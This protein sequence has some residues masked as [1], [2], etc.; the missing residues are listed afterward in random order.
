MHATLLGLRPDDFDA[1]DPRRA[2]SN[3]YSRP[4]LE[5]KQ[6]ALVWARRVAV[7]LHDIGIHVDVYASEEHP[8]VRNGYRVDC[9]WV[10]LTRTA[11]EREP[12][13]ALLDQRRGIA[14]V[15]DQS[16]SH[17]HAFLALR[18]DFDGV[19]VAVQVHPGA[20]IDF[21]TLQT[22]L[23]E[24]VR[25]DEL[26]RALVAL[27]EQ[28]AF[29]IRGQAQSP[30]SEATRD[31]LLAML[32]E[33]E[34]SAAAVR[35]GWSVPRLVAL[36][37]ADLLD[38][39]LEDALVALASL[40]RHTTWCP[41]DDPADMGKMIETAREQRA[42][43]A[44]CRAD[45][46][47]RDEQERAALREQRTAA[48]RARTKERVAYEATRARP[49]LANLFKTDAPG[50]ASPAT[51][52]NA[53]PA[54]KPDSTKPARREASQFARPRASSRQKRGEAARQKPRSPS[55][56][57]GEKRPAAT[58]SAYVPGG[59]LDKGA[60]VRVLRGPF[61]GK[62]GVL[63]D[64][65]GRGGARVLLGLLAT[66]LALDELESVVEAKDR[67]ALQS[68][69]RRPGTLSRSGK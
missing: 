42:R 68:S 41:E 64:T 55:E 18:L 24:P 5:F 43:D 16:P 34:A 7:R 52:S 60:K 20:W 58:E 31:N 51:P 1:Y 67:P 8:S 47:R 54:T 57:P 39:Q 45:R 19:E 37:H 21:K 33:V 14:A 6:R 35:I 10:C 27:P 15:L 12:I 69:H 65:D 26:V 29:G 3:A 59:D 30:C 32:D 40:Y 25:G 17:R 38:E 11:A 50:E 4:R 28:F 53:V 22:R 63:S 36:E 61:A 9:Q 56:R 49:T 23:H 44:A 62:I 66:R 2:G 13:D 48:S 46:E